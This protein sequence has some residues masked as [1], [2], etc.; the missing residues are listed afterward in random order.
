[1][2][3][4]SIQGNHNTVES[5]LCIIFYQS[6]RDLEKHYNTS[7]LAV[8]IKSL[9]TSDEISDN[10]ETYT[11]LHNFSQKG[12]KRFLFTG[13]GKK[14]LSTNLIRQ[15]AASIAKKIS[16]LKF[17]KISVDITFLSDL[18]TP[19]ICAAFT[20]G[21][22]LGNYTFSD[23]KTKKK[24]STTL[25]S[26]SFLTSNKQVNKTIN[27][28]VIQAD[29]QNSAR[30]LA[31]LPGNHLTPKIFVNKI[32]SL[33]S[34][35]SLDVKVYDVKAIQKKGMNALYNVGKGSDNPPYLVEVKYNFTK[36][37]KPAVIVGKGITF[38]SGGL[39]LKSSS[40]MGEMKADMSG[41]A[42]V[43]GALKGLAEQKATCSVIG[44]I[45]L[46][47]NMPSGSA[48]RPGDV[49]SSY[50]GKTIEITNTDAEGRLILADSLSYATEFD[51]SVIID[52]ATLTGASCVALGEL[53]AAL[54]G[55]KQK[56]ISSFLSYEKYTGEQFWQLPLFDGYLNYL[57]SDS[58]DLINASE[59]R[60]SG[61]AI[62]AAKFL[63]QFVG[64][65]N[66]LHLDIAPMMK[67]NKSTPFLKNGMT[68]FSTRTLIH[69][70][71]DL[72]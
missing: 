17:N 21:F 28:A 38:D 70:L 54:F 1:M 45:P 42:A 16:S 43:V 58:A 3:F 52:I 9:S 22:K 2:K 57:K 18:S 53:S 26:V 46:A 55:N 25:K 36:K 15:K 14:S 66:W 11:F 62:T 20:E 37:S 69:F 33:L 13:F 47:E 29:A 6:K 48:Y 56:T 67:S 39:S 7:S 34:H 4:N 71:R 32:K 8:S 27:S 23:L 19:D 10:K 31:N 51:P 49:I 65:Y 63:E 35:N 41:A 61:G 40:G 64:N 12:A 24:S 44:L 5:D 72:T 68:G 30:Y 50:S 60:F 59:S